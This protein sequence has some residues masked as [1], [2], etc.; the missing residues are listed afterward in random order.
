[1]DVKRQLE[2]KPMQEAIRHFVIASQKVESQDYPEIIVD[3]DYSDEKQTTFTCV[4]ATKT[5]ENSDYRIRVNHDDGIVKLGAD[6]VNEKQPDQKSFYYLSQ[7]SLGEIV[8]LYGQQSA[9]EIE[10]SLKRLYKEYRNAKDQETTDAGSVVN[11]SL[12]EQK[13]DNL[14]H[15][16]LETNILSPDQIKGMEQLWQKGEDKQAYKENFKEQVLED[17]G[18]TNE[19]ER[20]KDNYKQQLLSVLGLAKDTDEKPKQK[21]SP[22]N[23]KSSDRQRRIEEMKAFEK[24]HSFDETYRLKKEALQEIKEMGLSEPQMEK[25][26]KIEKALDAEKQEYDKHKKPHSGKEDKGQSRRVKGVLSRRKGASRSKQTE[27]EL[28]R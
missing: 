4:P 2:E 21:G 10:H 25:L 1:M 22:D 18:P 19:K 28:E 7:D 5:Q 12:A 16:A 26:L 15:H 9:Q 23:G 24:T 6:I 3:R 14:K 13:Y 27:Q 8:Q 20:Y 11:R 17:I